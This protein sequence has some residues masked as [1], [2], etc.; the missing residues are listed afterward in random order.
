MWFEFGVLK[1]WGIYI[2]PRL[3]FSAQEIHSKFSWL[4][5]VTVEYKY[6]KEL[7]Q[8]LIM[9]FLSVQIHS[10]EKKTLISQSNTKESNCR[11]YLM[12]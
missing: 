2:E 3:Y 10:N 9:L 6:C 5:N 12:V 1:P 8:V 4:G 7:Y 11:K